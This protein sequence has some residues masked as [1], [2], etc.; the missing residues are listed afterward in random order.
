MYGLKIHALIEYFKHGLNIHVWIE[1]ACM[2]WIY[3]YG[4]NLHVWIEY[5]YEL[6]KNI[7]L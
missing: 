2:D 5:I 7:F 1:Y 4:L 3:M 6:K